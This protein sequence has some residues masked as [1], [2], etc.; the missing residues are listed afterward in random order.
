MATAPEKTTTKKLKFFEL[1]DHHQ[2]IPRQNLTLEK[3]PPLIYT[4]LSARGITGRK[5]FFEPFLLKKPEVDFSIY[6]LGGL[7]CMV[8][9][10]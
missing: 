5:V 6:S 2:S 7:I 9:Y 4:V 1:R 8:I 10:Q 3:M